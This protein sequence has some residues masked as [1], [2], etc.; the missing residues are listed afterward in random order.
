MNSLEATKIEASGVNWDFI[1]IFH[2]LQHIIVTNTVVVFNVRSAQKEVMGGRE[3]GRK[4]VMTTNNICIYIYIYATLI[5]DEFI[6]YYCMI[7]Q[8]DAATDAVVAAAAATTVYSHERCFDEFL[9]DL[10]LPDT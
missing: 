2:D 5:F 4:E 3:G 7:E 9:T 6:L 8:A 10:F 1:V